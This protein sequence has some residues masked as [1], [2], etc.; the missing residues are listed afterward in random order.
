MRSRLAF[1][2]TSGH[3]VRFHRRDVDSVDAIV[4]IGPDSGM[5]DLPVSCDYLHSDAFDG[6]EKYSTSPQYKILYPSRPSL[7]AFIGV[8]RCL[9]EEV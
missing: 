6:S 1:I 8:F 5:R 9:V 3:C 4:V 7:I 2:R